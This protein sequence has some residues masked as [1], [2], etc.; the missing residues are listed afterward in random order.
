MFNDAIGWGVLFSTLIIWVFM[1]TSKAKNSRI[2]SNTSKIE[3]KNT[4]DSKGVLFFSAIIKILLSSLS[5][6][7]EQRLTYLS[8]YHNYGLYQWNSSLKKN[9]YFLGLDQVLNE[10]LSFEDDL[11]ISDN[12]LEDACDIV[13]HLFD[14]PYQTTS[15]FNL[16]RS[17]STACWIRSSSSLNR[18][19]LDKWC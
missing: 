6:V 7:A 14:K 15:K 1:I 5:M 16:L 19:P 8:Y 9:Y 17:L 3:L 10:G 12:F 11:V 13:K 2:K 4:V 18:M